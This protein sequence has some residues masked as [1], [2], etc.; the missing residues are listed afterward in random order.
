MTRKLD[1]V[2]SLY[3][4]VHALIHD[5]RNP[6]TGAQGYAQLLREMP[7]ISREKT[8]RLLSKILNSCWEMEELLRRA[9]TLFKLD[10]ELLTLNNDQVDIVRLVEGCVKSAL[11]RFEGVNLHFENKTGAM[12]LSV[13]SD[14]EMLRMAV[15]S[16]LYSSIAGVD[17]GGRIA[18]SV[19]REAK[20]G[21]IVVC[22]DAKIVPPIIEGLSHGDWKT[23]CAG[24]EDPGFHISF[25]ALLTK[26][27]GMQFGVE[28]GNGC[29]RKLRILLPGS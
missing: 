10:R 1:N 11:A 6:L 24:H 29:G 13:V 28:Q 9:S 5:V 15:D 8:D 2:Q 12:P 4:V 20:R 18:V 7:D 26:K 23:A 27:L 3:G 14:E 21:A 16:L 25:I 17:T 22:D 19:A